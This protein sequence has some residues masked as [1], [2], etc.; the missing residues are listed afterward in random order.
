MHVMADVYPYRP[1]GDELIIAAAKLA[2]TGFGVPAEEVSAL[3]SGEGCTPTCRTNPA[4]R[5]PRKTGGAFGLLVESMCYCT[6]AETG[7]F[8]PDS[9]VRRFLGLPAGPRH[10]TGPRGAVAPR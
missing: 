5:P 3:W 7:G 6:S 2:A 4:S 1:T 10:G 8:I 9:Q